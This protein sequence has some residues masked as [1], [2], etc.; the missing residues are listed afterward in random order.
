M[1]VVQAKCIFIHK[2]ILK[3]LENLKKQQ[4]FSQSFLVIEECE[5]VM[6]NG[7]FINSIMI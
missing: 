1:V 6:E 3:L 7:C 2:F 5:F 4:N